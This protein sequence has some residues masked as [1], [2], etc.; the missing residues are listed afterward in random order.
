[1]VK[2]LR[3]D[4]SRQVWYRTF[5]SLIDIK[6]TDILVGLD[7]DK[8]FEDITNFIILEFS[9]C[10]EINLEHDRDVGIE[11]TIKGLVKYITNMVARKDGNSDIVTDMHIEN[12]LGNTKFIGGTLY[13]VENNKVNNRKSKWL[14]TSS[15]SLLLHLDIWNKY[16][17]N[18]N[19]L[20]SCSEDG[21]WV[22]LTFKLEQMIGVNDTMCFAI[23]VPYVYH[24]WRD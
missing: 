24:E 19:E 12:L 11:L 5:N 13:P 7:T 14:M 9:N 8:V 20:V 21:L 1:M 4:N 17:D 3:V 2:T 18:I 15:E 10:K 23:T 6:A 22:T 16:K